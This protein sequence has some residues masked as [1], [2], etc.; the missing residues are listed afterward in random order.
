MDAIS[1]G[2]LHYWKGLHTQ[3]HLRIYKLN[4]HLTL[5]TLLKNN[6]PSTVYYYQQNFVNITKKQTMTFWKVFCVE[7]NDEEN[8][9]S[10]SGVWCNFLS[11]GEK[12]QHIGAG[13]EALTW[14]FGLAVWMF[15]CV[16]SCCHIEVSSLV[17]WSVIMVETVCGYRTSLARP[18]SVSRWPLLLTDTYCCPCPAGPWKSAFLLHSLSC[19]W[20]L[21]SWS[22]WWSP[23]ACS[24][25][26]I[27]QRKPSSN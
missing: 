20:S 15:L 25:V 9:N 4:F 8:D 24:A 7:A 17:F 18:P 5:S 23:A 21:S 27:L 19:T 26:K 11:F 10:F 13:T 2:P 14:R 3:L 1:D 22:R 12:R 16:I 6:T